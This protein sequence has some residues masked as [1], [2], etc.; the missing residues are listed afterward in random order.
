M[1]DDRVAVR[2]LLALLDGATF[3]NA[4]RRNGKPC[5]IRLPDD[6]ESRTA[7]VDAHLR[8]APSTLTFHA[9]GYTPWREQV[10]VVALAAFCP[11]ADGRCP[12]V[13]IDLDAADHGATGLV[14]PMY[15]ARAIAERA[16]NAGLMTGLL[17]AR[18]RRG[19]G[20]R[21]AEGQS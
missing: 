21:G 14:D 1:T 16:A 6:P 5:R 7:I 18:S 8:G 10:D 20:E 4:M 15:A 19:A 2:L 11:A 13:G 3:A 12:W 17:I 9:N